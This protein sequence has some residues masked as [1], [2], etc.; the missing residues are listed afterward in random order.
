VRDGR[1]VLLSEYA[2]VTALSRF[3]ATLDDFSTTFLRGKVNAYGAWQ[4][5][6]RS[7]LDSPI[8]GTSNLLVV[9]FEDLRSSPEQCFTRIVEFLGVD[10]SPSRIQQAISNNSLEKMRAKEACSPQKSSANGRFVRQGAVEGWRKGLSAA[11]LARIDE[12]VGDVLVRL[13]YPLSS[14]LNDQLRLATA[15][16]QADAS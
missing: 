9:R 16:G 7:W 11:Q 2:F 12:I 1:D 6:V 13:R 14:Q 5:H 3:D 15:H 4:N 8:A 10:A